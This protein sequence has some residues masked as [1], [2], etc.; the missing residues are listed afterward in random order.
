MREN[1]GGEIRDHVE[2][3]LK[4]AASIWSCNSSPR[5]TSLA[6]HCGDFSWYEADIWTEIAKYLD[7]KCLVMLGSTNRWFHRLVMEEE[8]IWKFACLRDMEVPEPPPISFKWSKLYASAFDGS[9]SYI[10]RQQ[11]KHIDWMR[12]GAFFFDS[13]VAV[14]TDQ[15]SLPIEVPQGIEV[16]TMLRNCGFCVLNNIKI[17]IWIADLQLVRCP[18]CNLDTCEGTMQTLDARH[19]ELFLR[20][21]FRNGTWEYKE[22]ACHDIKK[23]TEGATGGIFDFKHLK[24]RST[25]DILNIKLWSSKR[26]DWQP[27]ARISLHA[28]AVNTNLQKNEGLHVTFQVMRDETSKEVVSIRISQQLL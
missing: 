28:V 7:G 27:K 5:T 8:N 23:H 9:H 26:N 4:R 12:I 25:S 17:G 21:E 10:F 14:L 11:E 16:D 15:L 22:I 6:Q 19:V 24:D 3:R 18:V 2:K 20:E 1:N 13:N